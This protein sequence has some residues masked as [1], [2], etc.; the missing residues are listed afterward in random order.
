MK[1]KKQTFKKNFI[2][3]ARFCARPRRNGSRSL[4]LGFHQGSHFTRQRLLVICIP[5]DK[6]NGKLK[7]LEISYKLQINIPLKNSGASS[8][9]MMC[10]DRLVR[11]ASILICFGSLL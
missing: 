11:V 10:F 4:P 3:R 8:R 1:E 5:L 9:E 7:T 2:V 6:L